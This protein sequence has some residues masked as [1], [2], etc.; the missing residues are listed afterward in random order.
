M[1]D[2]PIT[3][4][5]SLL[6]RALAAW[7]GLGLDPVIQALILVV[8]SFA[9]AR[10]ASFILTRVVSRFTRKTRTELD[11]RIL[12][13]LHR[14]VFLT[15]FLCGLGLAVAKLSL[16]AG[17]T[18]FTIRVLRTIV[19]FAWLGFG[20]R[21]CGLMLTILSSHK[22]RLPIIEERT[23]P[24]FDNLAKI[25]LVGGAS[26]AALLIWNI[27][28][29]AWL[30]SAGIIGIAVGFA[31]KDTLA[32]LF[33]GVFIIADTPYSLGDFIILDSGERGQVTQVGIRSTRLLTRDDVE[34]IIP[35]NVIA[36]AKIVNESGGPWEKRR[37]RVKVGVAYGSD[38]DLV[39]QVLEKTAKGTENVCVEPGPRVRF[40]AFGD[41]SLDFE[42]LCWI[43]QPVDSGRIT[44]RLHMEVYKAFQ[45]EGIEIPFPQRDVYVRQVAAPATSEEVLAGDESARTD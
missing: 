37:V 28:V 38:V 27:D 34:I 36:N 24:L 23:I 21:F 6:D 20:F 40:R 16:A 15:V 17:I 8:V 29:T 4:V 11:D 10:I 30:T 33:S 39:C 31:A 3:A 41:S 25:L 43:D 19:V 2:S 26:Y 35:N 1:E 42:L 18:L 5:S 7:N 14:P 12:A 9:A 32:N 22:E 44:H 13:I 45:R